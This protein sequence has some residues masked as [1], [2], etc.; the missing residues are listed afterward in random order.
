MIFHKMTP[1]LVYIYGNVSCNPSVL[2]NKSYQG[3]PDISGDVEKN[4]AQK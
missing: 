1:W 3:N 2:D 4:L